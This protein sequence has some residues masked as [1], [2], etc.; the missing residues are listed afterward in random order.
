MLTAKVRVR[1]EDDWTAELA[2]YDVFGEFLASTFRDRQYIGIITLNAAAL[3]EVLS[4]IEGH[5]TTTS[6]K[7][8]ERYT[9]DHQGRTSATLFIRGEL[10]EFTPLQT[11]LYEGFLPLRPT[12]LEDGCECFDLLLNNRDELAEAVTMLENFGDVTVER[13]SSD[14]RREVTPSAAEWQELLSSIPPR[15]RELLNVAIDSGYFEIPRG[16]TLEELADEMDIT[17]A[18]ASNHLRRAERR[19]MEFFVRYINLAAN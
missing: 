4:V 3:D 2:T 19:L 11:L 14:F 9:N 15:Q 16:A 7:V 12:E 8:I 18:T 10:T 5:R 6:V 1:Y 13:I 17:K